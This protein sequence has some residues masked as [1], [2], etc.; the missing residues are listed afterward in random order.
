MS[1]PVRK[2]QENTPLNYTNKENSRFIYLFH[3]IFIFFFLP[4]GCHIATQA[5]D[6]YTFFHSIFNHSSV[7]ERALSLQIKNSILNSAPQR[8]FIELPKPVLVLKFLLSPNL[9][10]PL[11]HSLAFRPSQEFHR[12]S[13]IPNTTTSINVIIY[14]CKTLSIARNI[15]EIKTTH[16]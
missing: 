7:I 12:R 14:T 9:I 1:F 16:T 15:F 2:K 5:W 10:I 13:F 3:F 11:L 8:A 4:C 6:S